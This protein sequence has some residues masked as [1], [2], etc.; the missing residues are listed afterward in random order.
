MKVVE[1]ILGLGYSDTLPDRTARQ[2]RIANA[3]ALIGALLSAVSLPF[4]VP[5]GPRWFLVFDLVALAGFASCWVLNAAGHRLASR[6]VML[7]VANV[8]F[9]SASLAL[10]EVSDQ[11]VVFFAL[12]TVPFVLFDREKDLV[13]LVALVLLAFAGYFAS[14]YIPSPFAPVE[15]SVH[16]Y[17]IYSPMLTFLALVGIMISAKLTH[18]RAQRLLEDTRARAIGAARMAALGEMSSGVAHEIRNPLAAI[19]LA[20]S[21]L[22]EGPAEP[23]QV[24]AT[25]ARL[26][27]LVDRISK[28]IDSLLGFARDTSNEP[29]APMKVEQIVTEALDL[30]SKRFIEHQIRLDIPPISPE[31]VVDCRGTQIEQ[32]LLNLLGNAHDAVEQASGERWVRLEAHTVGDQ[33]ELAVS[34]SGPGVPPNART[35]IFDPF[36]TL[37]GPNRGT[38]LGLSLSRGIVEA[39]HG[40]IALDETAAHTRFVVRIPLHQPARAGA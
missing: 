22:A 30:C 39:H 21:F 10:G 36:F 38:G 15:Y 6:I 24:A 31:L 32:V 7:A 5:T 1:R 11:R 27:R 16:A 17:R 13:P 34:D 14:S 19:D 25:A 12:A 28:I 4:D 35:R 2:I 9:F 20:A 37:K 33:A 29:F 3:V 40:T 8:V 26:K 23:T 18:Q